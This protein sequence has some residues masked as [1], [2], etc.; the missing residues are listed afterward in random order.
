MDE[1]TIAR[2]WSKVDRRGPDECW[3]WKA[4]GNSR[5]YGRFGV[6]NIARL[7]HRISFEIA[8]GIGPGGLCVC[9]R[10]DNPRCVNPAHL[11][12]GTH[13]DNMADRNAKGRARGGVGSRNS[14]ARITEDTVRAIRIRYAAG[15]ISYRGLAREYQ[16]TFA[17]ISFV[18]RRDSWK[19]VE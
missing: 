4:G 6:H 10:C 18:V 14:H 3:E 19:H 1:K 11:F 13:A 2:F 16:T 9:H 12:L 5:G 17:I 8:N 7:A 15:G